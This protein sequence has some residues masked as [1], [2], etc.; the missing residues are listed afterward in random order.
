LFAHVETD[1]KAVLRSGASD[2]V[3]EETIRRAVWK[4]ELKHNINDGAAF[5]RTLKTMSQIG[6]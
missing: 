5:K 4:K 3:L 6:G 1:L 2:E